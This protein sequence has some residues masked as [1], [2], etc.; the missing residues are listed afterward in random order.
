MESCDETK[1]LKLK[2]KNSSEGSRQ[3]V[4][5]IALI[6]LT[7]SAC[8]LFAGWG[9]DFRN[10][11]LNG[12]EMITVGAGLGVSGSLAPKA[13]GS[14]RV[15]SRRNLGPNRTVNG[16]DL[17]LASE[18]GL[19]E[20]DRD[21]R[22]NVVTVPLKEGMRPNLDSHE[23]IPGGAALATIG[24]FPCDSNPISIGDALGNPHPEFLGR[25]DHARAVTA[26][27]AVTL[28]RP[29]PAAGR[30][31]QLS[32]NRQADGGPLHGVREAHLHRE[33]LV[34]ASLRR[35]SG[36]PRSRST[37]E[38][39]ENI[40]EILE[41]THPIEID[42]DTFGPLR[43]ASPTRPPERIE[44]GG[45]ITIHGTEGV[46]LLPLVRIRQHRVGFLNLFELLFGVVVARI[47]I[48]VKL[49]RE[50]SVGL[51]NIRGVRR[52]RYAERLVII[53]R[54][55]RLHHLLVTQLRSP[56]S[57]ECPVGINMSEVL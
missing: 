12:V 9:H 49:A 52:A 11:D 39:A 2:T 50:F 46:V 24:P 36:S 29:R 26:P 5:W 4:A 47:D 37:E 22:V 25:D 23:Q 18:V 10:D 38:L 48:R 56:A 1:H 8:G 13:E 15:G 31:L 30:T 28:G 16:P 44:T 53:S 20:G 54:Q 19:R 40:A 32:L 27:T 21:G 35:L 3:R 57:G 33:F 6:E 41:T 17:H 51:L 55:S 34:G 43:A 7:D 45:R 42:A 14:A